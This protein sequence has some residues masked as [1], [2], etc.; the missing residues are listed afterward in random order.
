MLAMRGDPQLRYLVSYDQMLR[1]VILDA[2]VPDVPEEAFEP[3]PLRDTDV[4]A[5]QE[6]IQKEGRH[7]TAR[8]GHRASSRRPTRRGARPFIQCRNYL[9]ALHWDGT[10]RLDTWLCAHLG[11]EDNEYHRGIGRMFL[12]PQWSPACSS[13]GARLTTCSFSR[14]RR[15]R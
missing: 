11:A 4:T 13:P 6:H 2:P 15:P 7:Q 8:K 9:T 1:A 10:P 12:V 3:R 5:I 14:A